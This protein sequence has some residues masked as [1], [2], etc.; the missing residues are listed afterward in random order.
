MLKNTIASEL[1]EVRKE[2]EQDSEQERATLEGWEKALVWVLNQIEKE[3]N[4]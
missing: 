4:E 3:G 1:D 2:I